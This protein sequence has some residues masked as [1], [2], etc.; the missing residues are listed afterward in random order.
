MKVFAIYDQEQ[1]RQLPI[2]YLYCYLKANSYIIELCDDLN[3][4]ETPLLFQGLVKQGIYTVPKELSLLW[5]RERVIPSGR[6]NIGLIL[7]NAKLKE[8]NETALLALSNG[9][10][11]QDCCYVTEIQESEVPAHISE[12]MNTN[13]TECFVSDDTR[14]ICLFRDHVVSRIDLNI[15]AKE[16]KDAAHLLRNQALLASVQVGVGGYSIEFPDFCDISKDTL[17]KEEWRLPL[18]ARDFYHF[19][20][21]NV[22]NSAQACKMLD[23]TK[24]NLSYL[25]KSNRIKPLISG[26][27]ENFFT[28][29]S[30]QKL[31]DE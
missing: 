25:A 8:Y 13:V 31:I 3:E 1:N 27:K 10:C 29:G 22:V 23:C 9:K 30:I 19:V 28:K 6:Q 16:N 21:R 26:A 12:R 7:K 4:W 20:Q 24:Q 17:R 11:S 18:D 5:V 14:I 2:G 15:L